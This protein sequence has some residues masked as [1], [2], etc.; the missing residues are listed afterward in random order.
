ME[1]LANE[2]NGKKFWR[3]LE[4]WLEERSII[5]QRRK[6]NVFNGQILKYFFP[7]NLFSRTI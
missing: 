4:T 6:L 5:M 1:P 7:Q 2:Y 3:K